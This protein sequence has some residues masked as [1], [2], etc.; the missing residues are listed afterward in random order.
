MRDALAVQ[1][2]GWAISSA[3]GPVVCEV[4]G[5]TAKQTPLSCLS[6]VWRVEDPLMPGQ[7]VGPVRSLITFAARWPT[8]VLIV[9]GSQG[10]QPPPEEEMGHALLRLSVDAGR[11]LLLDARCWY[12]A[13]QAQDLQIGLWLF[14]PSARC[15]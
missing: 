5:E 13:L 1:V 3:P 14:Q 4:L 11:S 10:Q 9:P 2:Q 12:R 6:A 15:S 8:E 7:P